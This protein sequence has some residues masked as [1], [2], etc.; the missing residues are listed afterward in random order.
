[1][2]IRQ[3]PTVELESVTDTMLLKM[4]IDPQMTLTLGIINT[5]SRELTVV[6]RSGLKFKLASHRTLSDRSVFFREGFVI[7]AGTGVDLNPTN[8]PFKEELSTAQRLYDSM[9]SRIHRT[10]TIDGRNRDSSAVNRVTLDKIIDAGGTVYIAALDIVISIHT[11]RAVIH[12]PFS[13]DGIKDQIT[14]LDADAACF[15]LAMYIVDNRRTYSDRYVNINGKIF[16]VPAVSRHDMADGFYAVHPTPSMV[17]GVA[18]EYMAVHMSIEDAE[19]QYQLYRTPEE[20][21]TFGFGKEAMARENQIRQR[22]KDLRQEERE[23]TKQERNDR[24]ARAAEIEADIKRR[25]EERNALR[26]DT[27]EILKFVSAIVI[28]VTGFCATVLKLK[29]G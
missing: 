17:G 24:L 19:K 23:E 20:A 29:K 13:D 2:T 4:N 7:A 10:P 9:R 15:R 3:P 14:Q 22:D 25:L 12:H 18:T 28:T 21:V 26:R 27:V 1:M 11:N 6:T 8:A 5:T 16:R